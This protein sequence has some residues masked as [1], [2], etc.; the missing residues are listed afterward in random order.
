MSEP[1]K[2]RIYRPVQHHPM[3]KYDGHILYSNLKKK[4]KLSPYRLC[5]VIQMFRRC[6]NIICLAM[7]MLPLF[8]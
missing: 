8:L 1:Q 2:P 6:D 7:A 4:Q 3:D 5:S